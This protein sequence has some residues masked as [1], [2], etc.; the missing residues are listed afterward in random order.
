MKK[1]ANWRTNIVLVLILILGAAI[2]SRLFFLQIIERKLFLA[3]ALGQQVGFSNIT[4]S[5]GQIFYAISQDTKGSLG[6]GEV[7]SL[8]INKDSWIISAIPKDIPNKTA[9]AELLSKNINQTKEQIL[10]TLNSQDSY[11]VLERNVPSDNLTKI[12]AL[13]LK[14]LSWENSPERFYPQGELAGQVLGFLGGEGSGQYGIEG[15]YDDILK[16]KSGVVQDKKGLNAIFSNESE[17]SLDGSDLYLT[18]DYNIQFQAESLLKKTKEKLDIESGQII[19]L[20]PNSVNILDLAN[21][22][23]FNSN[24]YSKEKN[25]EIFK[26]S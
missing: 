16:G 22:T 11:I 26:N 12:K 21:F 15:Y 6:T 10:L 4:G 2:I 25:F 13:N 5:R 14:G 7:K 3:Q 20:K 9:F 19:V 18:L 23:S 17:V 8:A 24:Q 1:F